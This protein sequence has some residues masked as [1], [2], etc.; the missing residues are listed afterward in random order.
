MDP[1]AGEEHGFLPVEASVQK[2]LR[3]AD[4]IVGEHRSLDAVL[5]GMLYVL[6][7]IRYFAEKPDFVLLG[8]MTRYIATFPEGFHHPKEDRYLFRLLRERSEDP[9]GV[10]G[11][12]ERE[13]VAS[14]DRVGELQRALLQYE[15]YGPQSFATF[16]SAV[17]SYAAFHWEHARAE[18]NIVLPW[19]RRVLTAQDWKEIDDAFGGHSDPLLGIDTGAQYERLFRHIVDLAPS[20]LGLRDHR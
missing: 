5:H 17:A 16:S 3:A 6:R 20:P 18:E 4:I 14:K 8:A 12:L 19:A 1:R 2:T 11:V 9:T 7:Q 15:H 13:H 10:L